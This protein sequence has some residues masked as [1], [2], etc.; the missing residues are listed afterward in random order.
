MHSKKQYKKRSHSISV[1]RLDIPAD[2]SSARVRSTVRTGS[3]FEQWQ[4]IEPILFQ[5]A[6]FRGLMKLEQLLSYF[7]FVTE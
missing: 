3:S 6:S 7:E 1:F 5:V 2:L 4:V